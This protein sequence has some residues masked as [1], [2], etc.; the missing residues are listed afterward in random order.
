M[1]DNKTLLV[2]G[3]SSD[4]GTEI[5]R[6]VIGDYDC[7]LAHFNH[8]NE[9]LGRLF[10]EWGSKIVPLQADFSDP[11]SV[12]AMIDTI[13]AKGYSP[14]HIVHLAAPKFA[15]QKFVK[16]PIDDFRNNYTVSVDSIINILKAFLP[17]MVKRKSGKIVFALSANV[18]GTPAKFQSAYTTVKYALLGLMK[19]L[20]VEYS[21]KG[22]T[23]NAVSPD[24]VDTKFLSEIPRLVIEQE[25]D[26]NPSKRILNV[27]EVAPKFAYLLSKEAD[28]ITGENIL[29]SN[30]K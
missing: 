15:I 9:A 23:V 24:M 5:I 12:T 1:S 18:T 25:A 26:K 28:D 10:E 20:A 22:I 29:V 11:D 27:T 4:I 8:E 17:D 13:K 7:V 6:E 16:E 19:S 30:L 21:D 3:A 14:D 2:T